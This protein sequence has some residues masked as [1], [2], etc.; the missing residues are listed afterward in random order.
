MEESTEAF[1]SKMRRLPTCIELLG[2][3]TDDNILK[4][5]MLLWENSGRGNFSDLGNVLI[6]NS[7]VVEGK[8]F[9]TMCSNVEKEIRNETLSK[10]DSARIINEFY[11]RFR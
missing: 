11:D 3:D 7:I 6:N 1:N 9:K 5:R 10:D 8:N 4:S 2:H